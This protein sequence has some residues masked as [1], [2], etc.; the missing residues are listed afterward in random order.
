MLGAVTTQLD[1]IHAWANERKMW[2]VYRIDGTTK[3]GERKSQMKAF[4]E[5]QSEDGTFHYPISHIVVP[6]ADSLWLWL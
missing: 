3:I 6:L 1:I 4:N 2:D 5:D